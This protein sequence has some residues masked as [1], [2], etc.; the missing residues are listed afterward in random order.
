MHCNCF[1]SALHQSVKIHIINEATNCLLLFNTQLPGN[2]L[3]FIT[4]LK[5]ELVTSILFDKVDY[6]KLGYQEISIPRSRFWFQVTQLLWY[7]EKNAQIKIE[8]LEYLTFIMKPV[9]ELSNLKEKLITQER[10]DLHDI[11]Y[12]WKSKM[13]FKYEIL[14][15]CKHLVD[16]LINHRLKSRRYVNSVIDTNTQQMKLIVDEE[17]EE[18]DKEEKKSRKQKKKN[19]SK[20]GGGGS[21]KVSGYD[22]DDTIDYGSKSF[23]FDDDGDEWG[24]T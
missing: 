13:I 11:Q 5:L 22:Y 19:Q 17:Q 9:V 18:K 10:L 23:Q 1:Y 8:F 4:E 12:I 2:N 24:N 20:S 14:Q 6:D 16:D 21:R 15:F 3:N 7:V